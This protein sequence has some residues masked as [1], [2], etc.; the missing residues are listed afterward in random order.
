VI[1]G[2][3]SGIGKA[4]AVDFAREG[5]DLLL[6]YLPEEEEDAR[7]TARW[8]EHAGREAVLVP[9]DPADPAYCREVVGRVVA[10]S[11]RIGVLR[12]VR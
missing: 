6:S 10:S 11:G 2:G 8:A 9:G 5:A 7:D 3:D 4:V 12:P 1:T